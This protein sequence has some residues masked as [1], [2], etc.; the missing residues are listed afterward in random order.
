MKKI[1]KSFTTVFLAFVMF[2]ACLF[3]ALAVKDFKKASALSSH[4][5]MYYFS[6]SYQPILDEATIAEEINSYYIKT[7]S[8][9][10]F[11]NIIASGNP[12][13]LFSCDE[14]Y[15]VTN[16][17]AADDSG[18]SNNPA[19]V[20]E[21]LVEKPIRVE[22]S[23][24]LNMIN[25]NVY[26]IYIITAHELE[27]SIIDKTAGYFKI[28]FADTFLGEVL[29]DLDIGANSVYFID[30]RLLGLRVSEVTPSN[31]LAHPFIQQFIANLRGEM[32]N[33]E[34]LTDQEAL[35]EMGI[36]IFISKGES[37]Y[38]A[39]E[40]SLGLMARYVEIEERLLDEEIL[41]EEIV[42]FTAIS[43]YHYENQMGAYIQS[44]WNPIKDEE[45]YSNVAYLL[46][47]AP[48]VFS[49]DGIPSL[50]NHKSD[51]LADDETG[52]DQWI[53]DLII[54]ELF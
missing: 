22:L 29:Y 1:R 36:A 15:S 9:S 54:A 35:R 42:E 45:G 4:D 47:V 26:D 44:L 8:P 41:E 51:V 40:L 43:Y 5:T 19:I 16:V 53:Q 2:F 39:V 17:G 52:S 3:P 34:T 37:E 6:D 30:H 46:A 13:N 50:M 24:F 20:L 11:A 49:S 18:F 14:Y 33:D 23:S 10:T 31:C 12:L 25:W 21:F 7:F 38:Q 48:Y 27:Q 28:D 32:C